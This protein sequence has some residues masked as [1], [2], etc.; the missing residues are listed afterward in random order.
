MAELRIAAHV[1]Q[2]GDFQRTHKSR[3]DVEGEESERGMPVG[4]LRAPWDRYSVS[5]LCGKDVIRLHQWFQK[6]GSG[7][8][9]ERGR[10]ADSAVA[11][12]A[13]EE[14]TKPLGR[15]VDRSLFLT[16]PLDLDIIVSSSISTPPPS[17]ASSPS[18]LKLPLSTCFHTKVGT[19]IRVTPRPGLCGMQPKASRED[20]ALQWRTITTNSMEL[21]L[22][23]L[24]L[25]LLLL[26]L[27][28]PFPV[29][30]LTSI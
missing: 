27:G 4:I 1:Q 15:P 9:I 17:S 16:V 19:D 28:N 2:T 22:V 29:W 8:Y 25:F 7:T 14:D 21:P 26:Q 24:M 20:S 18:R 23:D 30:N 5:T 11:L 3:Q 13:S 6:C 10:D 12:F